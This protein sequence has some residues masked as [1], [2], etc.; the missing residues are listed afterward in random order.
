MFF[1]HSLGE[2]E[3]FQVFMYDF[4]VSIC[5]TYGEIEWL[6]VANGSYPISFTAI[7][8]YTPDVDFLFACC[9]YHW[10]IQKLF[11]A[12]QVIVVGREN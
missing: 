12:V 2:I 1:F 10:L 5:N 11:W 7:G 6:A 8:I 3:V 9:K 4:F